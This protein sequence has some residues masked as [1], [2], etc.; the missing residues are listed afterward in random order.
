MYAVFEKILQTDEGKVIVR[1]HDNDRDAQKIYIKLLQVMTRSAEALMASNNLL[2]YLTNAKIFDGAWRGSSKSFVLSWIEKLRLHHATVPTAD[3][4]SDNVQRTMLQNAVLGL[5]ALRQ[6]QVQTDLQQ[7]TSSI[8]LTFQQHCS[9]LINAATGHDIKSDKPESHGRSR[10]SAFRSETVFDDQCGWGN[11]T[12][13]DAEMPEDIYDVDAA[14]SEL[15]AHA[16]NR[17]ERPQFPPGS[18]M[19]IARWKAL[20]EDAKKTWDTMEDSDKATILATQEQR[21]TAFKPD[22]SKFSVNA[23][24]TQ[25]APEDLMGDGVLLAMLTKQSNRALPSSHPAEVRSVLAQ[26]IKKTSSQVQVKDDEISVNGHTYVRIAK[27][28]D[29]RYDV[30]QASCRKQGLLVDR[31]ANGGIA[32]SDARVIA[33]HPH[34]TVDIRGID[35]HEI[36]SIPVVSAGAVARSQRGAVIVLFHQHAYHPQQGGSI[37]SLCQLEAFSNDVNDKSIHAPGGLQHN[38]TPDGHVF[39]LSIRDGLPCLAMRPCTDAEYDSLPHVILTGDDNW[40]PRALDLD[41]DEDD[42][43]YDAIADNVDHS[44]LFDAFGDYKGR[45]PDLEVSAVDVW[46]DAITPA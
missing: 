40:D 18:R 14:P 27:V 22:S 33:R 37:H 24:L 21:K 7:A 44:A 32:G 19:P 2:S 16:T 26:A 25:E 6:V 5:D 30:S 45:T 1:D 23:H 39:P 10:R 43:W 20:S 15:I 31:G 17:R 8:V 34:R 29:I 41:I 9:L 4:L 28:H 35:N 11:D 46:F 42:D 3:H 38:E 13:Y 12:R 36:T